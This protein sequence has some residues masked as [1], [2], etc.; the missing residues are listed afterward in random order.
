MI[1]IS[2]GRCNVQGWVSLAKQAR[3]VEQTTPSLALGSETFQRRSQ[4]IG[5]GC[6]LVLNPQKIPKARVPSHIGLP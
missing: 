6:A 1:T 4:S 2:E 3:Q 5:C